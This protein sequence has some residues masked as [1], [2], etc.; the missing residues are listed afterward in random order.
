MD[1]LDK[2]FALL[3][4]AIDMEDSMLNPNYNAS[5]K[6][7]YIKTAIYLLQ[8]DNCILILHNAG[9]Y[10]PRKYMDLPSWVP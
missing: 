8:R 6:D 5:T 2:I 9:V 1:P 3:G 7:V 4:I 10:L